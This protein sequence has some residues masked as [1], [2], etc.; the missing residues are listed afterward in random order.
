M[1]TLSPDMIEQA[2]EVSPDQT[3]ATSFLVSEARPGMIS[4]I[5]FTHEIARARQIVSEPML[6][7][8]RLQWWREALDE[9]FSGKAVRAQPIA[10][11][12]AQ[13]IRAHDLPRPWFDAMLDA[14]GTEQDELPF[15]TWAEL[16]QHGDQTYGHF[17]RLALLIAGAPAISTALDDAARQ[18]GIVWRISELLA[19]LPRWASRR[20]LWL[21]VEAHQGLD[22][23]AVFAGQTSPNLAAAF[24]QALA[25]MKTARQ[26]ANQA[27]RQA[28]F[29]QAFPA[30]AYASLGLP[31]AKGLLA[32][33]DPFRQS[34]G[35]SLLERQVRLVWAVARQRL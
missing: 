33:Q 23:E 2:A 19:Q 26:A 4:L 34:A 18:A 29:G 15:Q 14:F 5:L 32:L 3:L 24:G 30:L 10:Q 21:P 20:Q 25:R 28:S 16:L 27:C 31:Y 11:A 22:L 12:L 7:A 6:A 17:N 35:L 8:I 9:I 1:I 13:T